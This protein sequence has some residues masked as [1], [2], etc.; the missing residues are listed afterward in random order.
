MAVVREVS[1]EEKT[2][3]DSDGYD[4]SLIRVLKLDKSQTLMNIRTNGK[5]ISWQPDTGTDQDLMDERQF[6]KFQKGQNQK[7][8]LQPTD[9]KMYPYG[10]KTSLELLGC[11][12][13]KLQ[14]GR[15][16]VGTTIYVSKESSQYPLLS[17][18]SAQQLKLIKYNEEFLVKM[19]IEDKKRHTTASQRKGNEDDLRPIIK[20]IVQENDEV[21]TGKIGEYNGG[22]VQIII[23]TSVNP[24]VQKSQ[25]IPH[26]MSERAK[27]KVE[28]LL[29]QDIIEKVPENEARTWIS[30]PVIAPKPD[31][32]DIRFCVDIRMANHATKRPYA[33]IP[34]V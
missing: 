22:Q 17:E 30:P 4:T 21:F 20:K 16:M 12:D 15:H 33:Q 2:D 1:S 34:T 13:A 25:P 5:I 18:T 9:I 8:H 10:S 24:V 19:V 28:Q 31:S 29:Q 6:R 11:F 26:N 3:S 32:N 7:I 14:A 27:R 23:D